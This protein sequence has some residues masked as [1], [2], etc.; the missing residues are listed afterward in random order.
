[1][2]GIRVVKAMFEDGALAELSAIVLPL[3]GAILLLLF[4]STG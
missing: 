3:L 2:T 1:M 4:Y